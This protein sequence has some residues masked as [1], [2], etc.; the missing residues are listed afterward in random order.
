MRS[1]S[2]SIDQP[3][4]F[5]ISVY[6]TAP[7]A[8]SPDSREKFRLSLPSNELM[9]A[10]TKAQTATVV[11]A[12]VATN[13]TNG[14]GEGQQLIDPR[15][16]EAELWQHFPDECTGNPSER[17]DKHAGSYGGGGAS[18]GHDST[19]SGSGDERQRLTWTGTGRLSLIHI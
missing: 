10:E 12:A 9:P 17:P 5:L 13:D 2:P 6:S 3:G 16:I 19:G 15:K 11:A 18:G 14:K 1:I 4:V 8:D 7:T